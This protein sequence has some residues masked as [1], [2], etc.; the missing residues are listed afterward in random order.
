M[1]SSANKRLVYEFG[2]FSLDP[3]EK[4]LLIDGVP[5]HLPAKEFETLLLLVKN[6]GRALSKEEMISA[7][8]QDAF[9]EEGN[10]AKQVWKLRKLLQG[11]GDAVIETLPKHGY[12]FSADLRLVESG[13]EL[14]IIAER[15]TVKRVTFSVDED[16]EDQTPLAL[17]SK[18][19]RIGTGTW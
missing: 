15:R 16:N 18:P 3:G 7:V 4:K 6:N 13:D 19:S 8:W 2:S 12:R 17:P 14:P 1:E 10:L 9:V 11:K 5:V